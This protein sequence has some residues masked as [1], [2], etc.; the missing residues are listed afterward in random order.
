[1]AQRQFGSVHVNLVGPL[2]PYKAGLRYLLMVVDRY[3][4]WPEALPLQDVMAVSCCRAFL[5]DW[6]SR[7]GI[8]DELITDRGAQFTGSSWME[9]FTKMGVS[10]HKTTAYH[11]QS[12]DLVERMHR[13]LKAAL[14]ARLSDH[15]WIDKL[16]IVLLGL[17]SSW[18]EFPCFRQVR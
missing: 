13:Q 6:I 2:P 11:P 14:K 7:Y 9:F 18:K 4:R 15:D 10:M 1:M 5:R 16:P 12:N 17:R 3:S 8:L